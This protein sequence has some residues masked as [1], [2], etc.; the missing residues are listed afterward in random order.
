MIKISLIRDKSNYNKVIGIKITHGYHCSS[1]CYCDCKSKCKHKNGFKFH[2]WSISVHRF[3][4]YHFHIALP[5]LL[6]VGKEYTDLSGTTKCPFHKSRRYTCWSCK[7]Q[8][9]LRECSIPYNERRKIEQPTEWGDHSIC[10]NFEK[11]EWADDWDKDT[12]EIIYK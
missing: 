10:G 3:F 6:Y 11:C 12:G 9:G 8:R 7:N 5:Y 2:N 4:E 1:S